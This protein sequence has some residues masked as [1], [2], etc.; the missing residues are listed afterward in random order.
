[1]FALGLG[2]MRFGLGLGNRRDGGRQRQRYHGAPLSKLDG[3]SDRSG[4]DDLDLKT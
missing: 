4:V 2:V 1:M 3:D